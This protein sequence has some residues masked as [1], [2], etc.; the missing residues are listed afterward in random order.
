MKPR[1][2]AVLSSLLFLVATLAYPCMPDRLI[3]YYS[4]AAFTNEVGWSYCSCTNSNTS[5][6]T[7]AGN[8]KR[9]TTVSCTVA[10]I[11]HITCYQWDGT[12]WVTITCPN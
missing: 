5:G 7:Q 2:I 6:G 9:V 12:N 8:Y 3:E 11:T 1:R 10:E 4:D